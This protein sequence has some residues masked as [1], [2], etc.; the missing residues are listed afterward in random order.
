[1]NLSEKDGGLPP[2]GVVQDE[3]TI[4]ADCERVLGR[5]H[6]AREGAMLQV[7]LAP[8]APF[9]VTKRLMVDTAGLAEKHGCRLHTHLGETRD[10]NEY[11]LANYGCRPVDYL[12]ECGWL[13]NRVW[14]AHG[15]H[16]TDEEVRRLGRNRVGV[17][18]CPTSNMMLAS[19]QCRT[20]ELEAAG[21]PLGLGVDGSASNDNSNL[22]ESVRHALMI[23]RLTYS[24]AAVT[25]LDALRWATEGSARCL[26]RDDLGTIAVGK[27][28]DLALYTLD[29]LRFSGAGDP[30][31]ALVLCGAHAADRVMVKG[32]W[33]VVDGLP[34]G[35]DMA[36]LRAEH[37]AAAKAFLAAL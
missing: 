16:F 23:N 18:H 33:R 27:Q 31:A 28:A 4:L 15:I 36:K 3:D 21:S 35:V 24:A 37:G 34:V 6:D 22:M 2:D 5:Y 14:L 30:L 7:A 26:G 8:C 1:M 11:C 20:K 17:C 12:E 10:E 25:H 19:G 9:T 13:T 29:E 32:D